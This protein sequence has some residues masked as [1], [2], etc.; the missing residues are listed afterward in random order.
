MGG[1]LIFFNQI[2]PQFLTLAVSFHSALGASGSAF[3]GSS[4]FSAPAGAGFCHLSLE[5]LIP[6][7]QN[8][9]RVEM[10]STQMV[11]MRATTMVTLILWW[12]PARRTCWSPVYR[13]AAR[14]QRL[15][16][17]SDQKSWNRSSGNLTL[18]VEDEWG[19]GESEMQFESSNKSCSCFY[20]FSKLSLDLRQT[21]NVS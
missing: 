5:S 2:S 19:T 15:R 17:K 12:L 21:P 6:V 16:L 20:I 11:M 10:V 4:E 8:R 14:K 7:A 1:G 18:S 13:R 3:S 9:M